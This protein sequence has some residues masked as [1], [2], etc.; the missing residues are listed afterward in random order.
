MSDSLEHLGRY[1]GQ[2]CIVSFERGFCLSFEDWE[3]LAKFL[4]IPDE[5]YVT[6]GG[7]RIQMSDFKKEFYSRGDAIY[8]CSEH[9]FKARGWPPQV[10]EIANQL[11]H[12]I[13]KIN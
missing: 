12:L 3:G 2:T 7:E 8:V 5:E 11:N 4:Q 13:H 10:R 1:M 9:E 6:W